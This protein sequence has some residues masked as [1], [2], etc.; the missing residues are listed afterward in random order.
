[1]SQSA[2]STP[3]S[4]L[5]D[6]HLRI[7]AMLDGRRLEPTELGEHVTRV[8]PDE[9]LT[10]LAAQGSPRRRG[11]VASPSPTTPSSVVTFTTVRLI[12][13]TTPDAIR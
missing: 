4:G 13:G 2:I 9:C 7:T 6:D 8:T 3:A 1:M 5:S 12:P 10:E 11:E